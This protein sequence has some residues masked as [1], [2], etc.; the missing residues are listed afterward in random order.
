MKSAASRSLVQSGIVIADQLG[1]AL[2]F[3]RAGELKVLS[4]S[5]GFS[6]SRQDSSAT[7]IVT[8]SQM[9]ERS[10]LVDV[11]LVKNSVSPGGAY[12]YIT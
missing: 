10:I 9:N 8:T 7:T 1:T 6:S 4:R 3:P 11:S 12:A 2:L 5:A